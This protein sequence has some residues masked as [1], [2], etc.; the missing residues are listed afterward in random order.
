MLD[1]KNV[2]EK[3]VE[4]YERYKAD[5]LISRLTEDKV[6]EYRQRYKANLEEKIRE[7]GNPDNPDSKIID[8]Q[9]DALERGWTIEDMPLFE[10]L[11]EVYYS[12]EIE[13]KDIALSIMENI[14]NKNITNTA[15]RV[16]ILNDIVNLAEAYG[17]LGRADI[18]EG[19]GS[20]AEEAAERDLRRVEYPM[21][22]R[23]PDFRY[24]QVAFYDGDNKSP[25]KKEEDAALR[26]D[27]S[28]RGREHLSRP[29]KE[30][31]D[32]RTRGVYV[33]SPNSR[34]ELE[35]WRKNKVQDL[36]N[37]EVSNR[38]AVKRVMGE[39][40]YDDI[41]PI[42]QAD[43]ADRAVTIHNS[44]GTKLQNAGYRVLEIDVAGSSFSQTRQE[45][46]GINGL[47]NPEKVSLDPELEKALN[48]QYGKVASGIIPSNPDLK[49][50]RH[51]DSTVEDKEGKKVVKDRYTI[52]GPMG[53]IVPKYAPEGSGNR[54]DYKID[55]IKKYIESIGTQ[56]LEPIFESWRKKEEEPQSIYINLS[57][58]SRGAVA[59]GEG[60][61]LLYEWLQKEPQ[62]EYK[63]LIKFNIIQLDP[64]PGF[65]N[66]LFYAEN[67]YSGLQNVQSTVVYSM[68]TE[69]PDSWFM[70]QRIQGAQRVIIGTTTHGVGLNMVDY[71]QVDQEGDEK[72]HK[73]GYYDA[74]TKEFYRGSGL[75]ELPE[76]FYFTDE[77]Q[78]LI[79]LDSYSQLDELMDTVMG[80]AGT[81]NQLREGEL[82]NVAKTWFANHQITTSYDNGIQRDNA[83]REFRRNEQYFVSQKPSGKIEKDVLKF[84]REY[85]TAKERYEKE[86][87][88][89]TERELISA[90]ENLAQACRNYMLKT[91]VPGASDLSDRKKMNCVADLLSFAQKENNFI[92]NSLNI[93]SPLASNK[94][95]V[96]KAQ[97]RNAQENLEKKNA[98]STNLVN[99]AVE[100]KR[101]LEKMDEYKANALLG[102]SYAF[103][104]LRTALDKGT[105]VDVRYSFKEAN[106]VFNEIKK[107]IEE[108]EDYY[109]LCVSDDDPLD[110]LALEDFKKVRELAVGANRSLIQRFIIPFEK[111]AGATREK[112]IP[113]M[114]V[115]QEQEQKV[116]D[117]MAN[118][119]RILQEAERANNIQNNNAL[120]EGNN[121]QA[122]NAEGNVNNAQNGGN[123]RDLGQEHGNQNVLNEMADIVDAMEQH[124]ADN[125]D[126]IEIN[127]VIRGVVKEENVNNP[128]MP[129]NGA[130][131]LEG[132]NPIGN[133]NENIAGGE[134]EQPEAPA[135]I[136]A[137]EPGGL[138]WR[139]LMDLNRI[140]S[141]L[142][143]SGNAYP[144][145]ENSEQY[146]NMLSSLM[147]LKFLTKDYISHGESI[148]SADTEKGKEIMEAEKKV[149]SAS[150]IYAWNHL[151]K[152]GH[153]HEAGDTRLDLAVLTYSTASPADGKRFIQALNK[154]WT[155][156][157]K[158]RYENAMNAY[159]TDGISKKPGVFKLEDAE[160]KY[161]LGGGAARARNNVSVTAAQKLHEL[162]V[163]QRDID[164][165]I[166]LL[167]YPDAINE[168]KDMLDTK[169][170]LRVIRW[171]S[172]KYNNARDAV[173][174]FVR[175]RDRIV[176]RI[177]GRLPHGEKLDED[178]QKL[179][180][181][182][183]KC[184][185]SLKE[186]VNKVLPGEKQLTDKSNSAGIARAAGALGLLEEFKPIMDGAEHVHPKANTKTLRT[187][188]D[189]FMREMDIK[190][191]VDR[192]NRHRAAASKVK[193]AMK[194]NM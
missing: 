144:G 185:S 27:L 94:E 18:A 143:K 72:V 64:V 117:R 43:E 193:S 42:Y 52:S 25:K 80:E 180:D 58:H 41:D 20:L 89:E 155:A 90:V 66:H 124:K 28:R 174:D 130:R 19:L 21:D 7:I 67:D 24:Q 98:A 172:S 71:S 138:H 123:P 39:D 78:N 102:T 38:E 156:M 73:I 142:I 152:N 10:L 47:Y 135:E 110:E 136:P 5:R 56:Y 150:S 99:A 128:V 83:L 189:L 1:Q 141:L 31:R 16:E 65:G 179:V 101:L 11:A 100:C 165:M 45:Q 146:N 183:R 36:L 29:E 54:G 6:S 154:K 125:I 118:V 79:R 81:H 116:Q 184:A 50:I 131:I 59:A 77:R 181:D 95:N 132:A 82:R 178:F 175:H 145:H 44:L 127:D 191:A 37:A 76:G 60:M 103:D 75:T 188:R 148:P 109:K 162:N 8:F 169:H 70:P 104:R 23:I 186:Y 69:Y 105:Q 15:E 194:N 85:D 170:H 108:Y 87:N 158:E 22:N 137:N 122:N 129:G 13:P 119:E 106:S 53:R 62:S 113:F 9:I 171:N 111:I 12:P 134:K 3:N 163:S 88:L 133:R 55:N 107:S 26:A 166:R 151:K 114:N 61:K 46:N 35:N 121:I 157:E 120:N 167:N 49:D 2:V 63:D 177:N 17:T 139:K 153:W 126:N 96:A 164:N 182:Y 176:D 51:K 97:L 190:T 92:V 32:I 147:N 159:R 33:V 149:L 40:V 160:A 30:K 48:D 140:T 173:S 91:S 34:E 68:A 115:I 84:L 192:G 161:G 187:Y 74:A 93:R 14:K 4:V 86:I 112:D 168:Y 57:G